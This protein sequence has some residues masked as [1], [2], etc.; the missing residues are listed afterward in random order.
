MDEWETEVGSFHWIHFCTFW[1]K[2]YIDKLP[3]QKCKCFKTLPD[4]NRRLLFMIWNSYSDNRGSKCS[5]HR[6]QVNSYIFCFLW[7]THNRNI[8]INAWYSQFRI[9]IILLE[10]NLKVALETWLMAHLVM[11][12]YST[13]GTLWHLWHI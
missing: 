10:N 11:A 1:C 3:I 12:H 6:I 8:K 13:Y 7:M 2:N 9:Y 5:Y 4:R